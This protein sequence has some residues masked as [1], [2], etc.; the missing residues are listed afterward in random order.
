M[1]HPDYSLCDCR[2]LVQTDREG[3]KCNIHTTYTI[4]AV[5]D[6]SMDGAGSM[7]ND[8]KRLDMCPEH[9]Q[10]ALQ[11]LLNNMN[12]EEATEFVEKWTSLSGYTTSKGNKKKRS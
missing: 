2:G 4:S 9:M 8:V 7:E 12:Y 11:G 5:V 6:R 3:K 1:S 10:H